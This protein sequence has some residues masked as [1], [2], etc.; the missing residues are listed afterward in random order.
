MYMYKRL[1]TTIFYEG[2][3]QD[4]IYSESTINNKDFT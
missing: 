2:I 1:N 4:Y 3:C